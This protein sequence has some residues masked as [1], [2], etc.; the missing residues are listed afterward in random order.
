MPSPN[1]L[2]AGGAGFIGSH[3]AKMLERRGYRPVVF[4]NLSSGSQKAIGDIPFILGD[5]ARTEDLDL[6]FKKFPFN[7]VMHFAA[8]IDV[9]ESVVNP[10]KYY[11]HNV[12]YTLN[13]I[14]AMQRHNVNALIFSSSAA[15]FGL[16]QQ[17][18]I[19]ED[20]P[21]R[22]IN[23][24]GETKLMVEKILR[25][26]DTAYGLKSSCLRY[27]NA[28]GGD[29]LGEVKNFK[30]KEANLIPLVLRHLKNPSQPVT[31]FGADYP[32]PDGTCIRDYIHL[33]DLGTA[34]ILALEQLLKT[35]VSTNYNLGNGN[36]FS[37]REVIRAAKSVTGLKVSVIEGS[38]RAG[39]PAQ[40]IADARKARRE[41]GWTPH[42]TLEQ[43]IAHAWQAFT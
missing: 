23:P 29:P 7:A 19:N 20:H 40:L 27:F 10:L 1:I 25:D 36:G 33:E 37:V 26:C 11:V 15:I 42:Y 5:L 32:T 3:V 39:D 22:P 21:C 31:I 28:A 35:N 6:A 34:H 18:R 16:P 2:I 14:E 12:S 17:P 4:D 43:M 13:L 9:G 41:L 24:Y 30:R 8:L 38:R